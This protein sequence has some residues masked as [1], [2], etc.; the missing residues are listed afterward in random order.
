MAV[1]VLPPSPATL[2]SCD[3]HRGV[4]PDCLGPV[5]IAL[6]GE[7]VVVAEPHEWEPRAR[8]YVCSTIAARGQRR[9]N[10]DRCGGSGYVGERR[11][12]GR[13]LA[14]DVAWSDEGH[15]RLVGPRT[16]RKRGEALY[17]LHACVG[18]LALVA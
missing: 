10:C 13:M 16:T 18:R 2:S 11:P 5:L 15:V 1:A 9:S 6:L 3:P 12:A 8:C 7:H 14:V 17:A 4:C